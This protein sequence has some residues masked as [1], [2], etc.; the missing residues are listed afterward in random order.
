VRPR[1]RSL[2]ALLVLVLSLG[3]TTGVG[4]AAELDRSCG[5]DLGRDLPVVLV[6]GWNSA[7]RAW[8]AAATALQALDGVTTVQFD[9]E[10]HHNDWVDTDAIGPSLARTMVCLGRNS[11]ALGGPGKV[12]A[13][14]H[15]MGGLAIRCAL[16]ENC[17]G[18][19]VSG[20]EPYVAQVITVGTPTEGSFWRFGRS[21]GNVARLAFDQLCEFFA[22]DLRSGSGDLCAKFLTNDAAVAFDANSA[23]LG[24]LRSG[25]TH[26]PVLAIAGKMRLTVGVALGR[27]NLAH[28][29]AVVDQQ[30]QQ[31]WSTERAEVDCGQIGIGHSV[32]DFGYALR[33]RDPNLDVRCWHGSEVTN[34]DVIRIIHDRVARV[35]VQLPRSE[36]APT[37]L[38]SFVTPTGNMQCYVNDDP[39]APEA[40]C[41]ILEKDWPVPPRPASCNV[42]GWG[43]ALVVDDDDAHFLCVGD[44]AYNQN[45]VPYGTSV[46]SGS[47]QCDVAESGVTCQNTSTD[48]GFTVSRATYS[49]F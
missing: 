18:S 3:L 34:A 48:H 12:V 8:D 42:G 46:R 47:F 1:P 37:G 5:V 4:S 32:S 17:N 27:V 49:F 9:Y 15:S 26:V 45:V 7:P 16:Q 24:A 10:D 29:D 2:L 30:S 41:D 31:A 44:S 14:G 19:T 38:V 36:P 21:A 6:H 39:D 40:R 13:V 20:V 11:A 25:K 33:D 23:E 22:G 43:D 35:T 28:G